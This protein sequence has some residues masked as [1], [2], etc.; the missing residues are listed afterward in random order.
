[1]TT[2]KPWRWLS[3]CAL[4][5]TAGLAHADYPD[6]TITLVVPYAAGGGTDILARTVCNVLAT[7]LHQACVVDNRPGAGTIVGNAYVSKS[8]PDGYTLLLANNTFTVVAALSKHLGYAGV[9]AFSYLGYLGATPN[10]L[11]VRSDSP[12]HNGAELIASVRANPGKI[13]FGSPGVGTLNQMAGELMKT[14]GGL[15]MTHVPYKGA[16]PLITDVLGGQLDV[17]FSS[18]PSGMPFVK[19]GKV[20]ALAVTTARRS[21]VLPD[22]PTLA[23]SGLPGFD[24]AAWYAVYGPPGIPPA[25]VAMLSQALKKVEKDPMAQQWAG[26]EGFVFDFG[27]PE[28]LGPLARQ[29]EARWKQVAKAQNISLD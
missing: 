16:V 28:K 25:I 12:F 2:F 24:V 21:P 14:M 23:E 1:M 18:L 4:A 19:N 15:Q 29:E 5:A 6:H 3:A 7:D 13:N 22:V 20:R 27:G 8:R 26:L 17:S 10:V 11:L 9:E